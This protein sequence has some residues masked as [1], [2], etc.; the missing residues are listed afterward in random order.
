MRQ[1]S[2]ERKDSTAQTFAEHNDIGCH[3]EVFERKEPSGASEANGNFVQ[4]Q[5]RAM[6]VAGC[7][8]AFPVISGGY[9]R[10]VAHCLA[11]YRGHIPL[12]FHHILGIVGASE[13]ARCPAPKGAMR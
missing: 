3:A 11:N 2:R 1:D 13:R 6:F 9:D 10:Y 7:A 4:D 8:Y 12:A 5:Q